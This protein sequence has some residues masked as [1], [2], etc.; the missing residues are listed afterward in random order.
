[1]PDSAGIAFQNLLGLLYNH[2]TE[3]AL[4]TVF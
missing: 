1:M 2:K 4:L 3:A